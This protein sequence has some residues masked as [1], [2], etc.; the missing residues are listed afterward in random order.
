MKQHS[1][2]VWLCDTNR[3]A[4]FHRVT[5]YE[6][7]S[8]TC[9]EFFMLQRFLQLLRSLRERHILHVKLVSR[10]RWSVMQEKSRWNW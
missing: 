5:G 4:S 6:P 9:H 1:Y 2:T 7:H 10:K 8:F 3:I